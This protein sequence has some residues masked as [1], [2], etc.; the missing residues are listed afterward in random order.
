T[1][2]N[3]IASQRIIAGP[4]FED[5]PGYPQTALTTDY[6]W[7]WYDMKSAGATNWILV[8][9]PTDTPVTYQIKIAGSAMPI[10]PSNPGTI[11]A[12]DKVVP[13]FPGTMNGPVE[14]IATGGN[15]MVS[16]RVTWN[17]YFNEVLGTVLS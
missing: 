11:L 10:G 3:V 6:H 9:N 17:G 7:T 8:A 2:G 14:V 12:H 13:T 4:S 1:G 16:Q 15:V 5:V